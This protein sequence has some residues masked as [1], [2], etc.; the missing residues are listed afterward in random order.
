MNSTIPFAGFY[1]SIHDSYMDDALDMIFMD[2]EGDVYQALVSEASTKCNWE[3]VRLAYAED[4]TKELSKAS[5][6]EFTFESLVSPKEYNFSTDRIFVTI[7]E[8]EVQRIRDE[9]DNEVFNKIAVDKFK[10]RDGFHSFYSWNID[11]WGPLASWDHNQI[12][13]LLEAYICDHTEYQEHELMEDSI[14]NGKLCNWI[15]NNIENVERL[16]RIR[17]YLNKRKERN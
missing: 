1:Y 17:D 6:V 11:D 12:G 8:E 13:T 16:H 5:G 10:S 2:N 7:T 3:A 9:V 15:N 4:Y 14:G